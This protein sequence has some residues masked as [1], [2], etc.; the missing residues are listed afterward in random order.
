MNDRKSILLIVDDWEAQERYEDVFSPHFEVTCAPFAKTGYELIRSQLH[1]D[2]ILIDLNLEDVSPLEFLRRY[3]QLRKP[4]HPKLL[5]ILDEGGH[6]I[7]EM[8][9]LLKENEYLIPRPFQWT[10]L[11]NQALL[12]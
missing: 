11:L 2:V 1:F 7:R 8:K 10:A 3:S 6:D 9:A 4:S 12:T 5:I